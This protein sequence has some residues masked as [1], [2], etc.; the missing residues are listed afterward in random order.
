MI[1]QIK[2]H[3]LNN[4]LFVILVSAY[5]LM[6]VSPIHAQESEKY[7]LLKIHVD[8]KAQIQKLMDN[9]LAVDDSPT[10]DKSIEIIVN[11]IE[12]NKLVQSNMNFE[13]IIDNMAVYYDENIKKS[14]VELRSL[15]TEMNQQ[16]EIQGF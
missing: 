8:N 15:Q 10:M 4:K 2:D 13:I 7:S 16:Y 6:V 1:S 12:L 3:G 9:G 11:R 5:I 14:P